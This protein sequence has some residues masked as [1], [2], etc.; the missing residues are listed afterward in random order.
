MH[1]GQEDNGMSLFKK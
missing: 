1:N